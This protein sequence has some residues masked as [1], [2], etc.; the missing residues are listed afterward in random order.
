MGWV[1]TAR[2]RRARFGLV[3]QA[4]GLQAQGAIGASRRLG[5]MRHHEDGSASRMGFLAQQVQRALRRL[6]IEIAGRLIGQD[7]LRSVDECPC[8]RN[9]LLLTPR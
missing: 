1:D 7:E 5:R 3:N 8:Q 4:T 9:P 6:R 2:W